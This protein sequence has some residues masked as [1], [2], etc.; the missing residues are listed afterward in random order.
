MPQ[1]ST[2]DIENEIGVNYLKTIKFHRKSKETN[3]SSN[4]QLIIFFF[5]LM[6]E[7]A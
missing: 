2:G 5:T 7:D 1:S 6:L 4:N 3:R